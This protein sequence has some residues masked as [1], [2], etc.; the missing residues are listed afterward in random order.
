ME[1]PYHRN[2]CTTI[3]TEPFTHLAPVKQKN[4]SVGGAVLSFE[5]KYRLKN[6]TGLSFLEKE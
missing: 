1:K 5:E 4:W 6:S 2:P 3:F